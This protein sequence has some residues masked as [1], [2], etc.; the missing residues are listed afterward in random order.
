VRHPF[1]ARLAFLL[2]AALVVAGCAGRAAR[3]S[4]NGNW[5]N[6][7]FAGKTSFK[8][9]LVITIG[10]NE[11]AQEAFQNQMAATL[12]SRGVNAVASGAYFEQQNE[13]EEARFK[14]TIEA[15]GADA[16]LLARVLA[17]DE[18]ITQSLGMVIGPRGTPITG[19]P[20]LGTVYAAAFSPANYAPPQYFDAKSLVAET[21]L[22]EVQGK[23]MVWSAQTTTA[24]AN[25]GDLAPAVQQFVNVVAGAMARDKMP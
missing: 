14:R 21:M 1:S 5:V 7:Q 15:S 20:T 25:R 19:G 2:C 11:F 17:V 13:R 3:T 8:K 4:L 23:T 22:F 10:G 12:R 16:V 18:G 24:Y 6:P 9:V